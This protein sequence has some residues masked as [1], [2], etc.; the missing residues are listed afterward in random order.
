MQTNII[1][2]E[3][4]YFLIITR[5]FFYNLQDACDTDC[6]KVSEVCNTN[7]KQYR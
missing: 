4:V 3:T 1:H 5:L 2:I 7:Y 6:D